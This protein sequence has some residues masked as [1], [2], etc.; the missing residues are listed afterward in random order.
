MTGVASAS[1]LD[2]VRAIGADEVIDYA[3]E[4]FA[5]GDTRYDVIVDIG[6]NASLTRLRRALTPT[7]TV[8]IVGGET[9]GRWLGGFDRMLIA[10]LLSPFVGQDLRAVT[11]SEN[12]AD[13]VILGRDPPRPAW[14]EGRPQW[15][16]T[17]CMRVP[18]PKPQKTVR[19]KNPVKPGK[20]PAKPKR[21]T[22][23]RTMLD[24]V[25]DADLQARRTAA[26]LVV[27]FDVVS[28]S[29]QALE[30]LGLGAE[31]RAV[32]A[33][34]ELQRTTMA[35]QVASDPRTAVDLAVAPEH[36][37][38]E[39]G[40]LE[41]AGRGDPEALHEHVAAVRFEI[42]DEL[43]RRP[44]EL[45]PQPPDAGLALITATMDAASATDDAWRAARSDPDAAVRTAANALPWSELGI[46][47]GSAAAAAVTR[48][49]IDA[50]RA[51]F[52]LP[53]SGTGPDS[54]PPGDPASGTT[55]VASRASA[56]DPDRAARHVA[57]IRIPTKGVP[58]GTR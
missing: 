45:A 18:E 41:A 36:A 16:S 39:A 53:P 23:P 13:M 6:G 22:R 55:G 14:L 29:A 40:I 47:P 8:A 51:T 35:T 10:P 52:D 58:H 32:V 49:V 34:A 15:A 1:T 7:D 56:V 33:A 31:D 3:V 21:P 11:N 26:D 2:L 25:L 57:S 44:D 46:E 19:P 5:A 37:L 30:A 27:R 9:G 12:A 48:R 43:R 42:P 50:F 38:A 28:P 24:R 20:Q 4:D 54:G 17:G